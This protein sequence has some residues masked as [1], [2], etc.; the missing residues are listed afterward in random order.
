[1]EPGISDSQVLTEANARSALL[2]TADKDFGELIFRMHRLSAGI[3]LLRLAGLAPGAKADIVATVFREHGGELAGAFSV[4][5][6]GALRIRR[7]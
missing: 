7:Q 3:V 6:P 5:S 1:M 4:V 2:I